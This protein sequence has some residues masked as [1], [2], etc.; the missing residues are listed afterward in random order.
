MK[1]FLPLF[2]G[3]ALAMAGVAWQSRAQLPA[4]V[5]LY[6]QKTPDLVP[7]LPS[8]CCSYVP[9]EGF[10][11]AST[12]V[13]TV[14]L[15]GHGLPPEYVGHSAREVAAAIASY[16]PSLVIVNTCYGAS[17]PLLDALAAAGSRAWVVA[18]PYQL[19]ISGLVFAPD[20]MQVKDPAERAR[21]VRTEPPYPLLRW[22]I[23][24]VQLKALHARV[25]AMSKLELRHRL[26]RVMPTLLKIELPSRI[27]PRGRVLVAI[28]PERFK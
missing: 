22:Q 26:K 27:E 11:N 23:D 6:S 9:L 3:L 15:S 18:G 14:I 10:R 28:A 19:Y 4:M 8:N 1:L 16:K 12:R 24:P 17:T 5:V 21:R 20:F 2:L 25:G 13:D 7:K